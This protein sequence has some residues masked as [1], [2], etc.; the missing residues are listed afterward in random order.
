MIFDFYFD[1]ANQRIV[2]IE[3]AQ[4][5][6]SFVKQKVLRISVRSVGVTFA[7]NTQSAYKL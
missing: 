3:Y 6:F 5:R 1:T 2:N 4:M 7:T